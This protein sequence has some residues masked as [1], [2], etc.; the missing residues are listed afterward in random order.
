MTLKIVPS[1]FRNFDNFNLISEDKRDDFRDDFRGD[2]SIPRLF[3]MIIRN[4]YEALVF[5][6]LRSESSADGDI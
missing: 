2:L 1:A 5:K 6:L 3:P 4:S